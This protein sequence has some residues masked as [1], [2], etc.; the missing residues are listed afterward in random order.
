LAEAF[1]GREVSA[2]LRFPLWPIQKG[3]QKMSYFDSDSSAKSL[4][5]FRWLI[6]QLQRFEEHISQTYVNSAYADVTFTKSS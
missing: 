4:R 5:S 3:D 1:L 6:S 2:F